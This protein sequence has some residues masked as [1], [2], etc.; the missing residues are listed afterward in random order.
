[1]D[2]QVDTKLNRGWVIAALGLGLTQSLFGG[3]TAVGAPGRSIASVAESEDPHVV[4]VIRT[5]EGSNVKGNLCGYSQKVHRM[6]VYADGR[7]TEIS[8]VRT[9]VCKGS[10]RIEKLHSGRPTHSRIPAERLD[11]V[12]AHLR[13]MSKE[14]VDRLAEQPRGLAS[15]EDETGGS[16]AAVA[17]MTHS[18]S[19]SV[20]RDWL[21]TMNPFDLPQITESTAAGLDAGRRAQ[22]EIRSSFVK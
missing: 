9:L 8:T 12:L 6:Q 1:M 14:S 16:S 7:V 13:D 18:V 5:A 22:E 19:W 17:D 10:S 2:N 11:E 20:S 3:L 15:S 4:A 21:G